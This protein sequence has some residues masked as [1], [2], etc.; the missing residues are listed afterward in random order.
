[1]L[2]QLMPCVT[3][4]CCSADKDRQCDLGDPQLWVSSSLQKS[5]RGKGF[6]IKWK[7]QNSRIAGLGKT[8]LAHVVARHCGYRTVEIN[9]SDER[10][11]ATLQARISDAVQMQSVLGAGRPNCVIIDEID[12]ATGVSLASASPCSV[13]ALSKLPHT[14]GH[15]R[16]LES[17]TCMKHLRT[18]LHYGIRSTEEAVK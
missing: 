2:H 12:G 18:S 10:T 9:A 5:A 13:S 7:R 3:A 6:H 4:I 1:M 17:I 16:I 8:T 14:S 11:A 15:V